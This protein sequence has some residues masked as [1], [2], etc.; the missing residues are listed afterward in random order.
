M[1]AST[2]WLIIKVALALLPKIIAMIEEEK[3]KQVGRDEIVDAVVKRFEDVEARA[4]AARDN[5]AA[6]INNG[7]RNNQ[8]QRD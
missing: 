7:V 8:F 2:A 6:N 5:A 1:N 3:H 4:K